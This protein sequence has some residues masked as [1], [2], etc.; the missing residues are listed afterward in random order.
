ML[1]RFTPMSMYSFRKIITSVS[2]NLIHCQCNWNAL[3]FNT[4]DSY[5]VVF[6]IFILIVAGWEKIFRAA[7]EYKEKNGRNYFNDLIKVYVGSFTEHVCMWEYVSLVSKRKF[8]MLDYF[9]SFFNPHF[10]IIQFGF[11]LLPVMNYDKDK[12]CLQLR[13]CIVVLQRQQCY[14]WKKNIQSI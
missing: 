4:D 8:I 12:M 14:Q 2:R 7:L 13:P 9:I 6:L 5:T 1:A 11:T 3:I 10:A